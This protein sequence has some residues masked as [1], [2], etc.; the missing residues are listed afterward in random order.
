MIVVTGGAGFIGSAVVWALNKKGFDNILVVDELGTSEKWKNLV[1]LK[2]ADYEEKDNFIKNILYENKVYGELIEGIIHMGACSATTEKN[3]SY[4][5]GNNYQY[6]QVLA[7]WCAVHKKKFVY[8]SSAATYGD[9]EKGFNDDHSL[10]EKLQPLNMYAYSKH[11]FD[12]WALKKG[13]LDKIAG[14][15]FFNVFGPNEY[16]KE[17]MRSLVHKAYG[18]IKQTGKLKLFKSYKKDYPHGGQVRDFIYVQEAVEMV[19]FAYEKALGGIYNAG[20][21]IARSFED[22]GSAVFTAMGAKKNMEYIEMP[23][24]IRDKYQYY[25]QAKMDK[26]KAAGYKQ[27]PPN[28]EGN[29]KTYVQEFLMQKDSY[30]K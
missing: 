27:G 13:L 21:G 12:M 29:V 23:V 9:G 15:K 16:H 28:L 6:S 18:Q 25:T 5:I 3:A 24:E 22:L 2:F 26:L 1:N 11:M 7:Q 10:L 20:T 19:L 4:L 14:I 8:A 30:L 17:D